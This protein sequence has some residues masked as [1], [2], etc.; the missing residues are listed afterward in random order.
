MSNID[1]WG[2]SQV[3]YS[4]IYCPFVKKV[5]VTTI[6]VLYNYIKQNLC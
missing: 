3:D 1:E 2:Q 5:I 6:Y 4:L